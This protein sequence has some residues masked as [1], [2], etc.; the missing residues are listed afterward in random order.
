MRGWVQREK[1]SQGGHK[2]PTGEA[3]E[4]YDIQNQKKIKGG[5][6]TLPG[7]R[8]KRKKKGREGGARTL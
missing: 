3:K 8:L 4:D 6:E 7:W 1:K 2:N 5:I